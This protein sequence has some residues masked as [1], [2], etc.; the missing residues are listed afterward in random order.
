MHHQT[1]A[2][3]TSA[4]GRAPHFA[5]LDSLRG[6]AA[7]TVVFF[8]V[9]WVNPTEPLRIIR[10]G[11]LM[12]DLFFVLSGF[13]ISYA[14][15][16]RLTSLATVRRFM[17]LRFWRLYPV[18]FVFLIVYLLIECLKWVVFVRYGITSTYRPFEH[19]T[20]AA[21]VANLFL[22]H[23]LFSHAPNS[24]NTPSWSISV[25]F[26]TYIVFAVVVL[27]WRRGTTVVA[28]VLAVGSFAVLA[29]LGPYAVTHTNDYGMIRCLTG[30]F[31]GVLTFRAFE[32]L[33]D[34]GVRQQQM[35]WAAVAAMAIFAVYLGL[36]TPGA[37][38]FAIYPLSALVIL[39][40]A[41]AGAKGPTA[42][43]GAKPVVWLGTVSYSLYM[44]HAAVLWLVT[45]VIKYA[46]HPP[47]VVL[48]QHE[49]PVLA[50]SFWV[51][52]AGICAGIVLTLIVAGFSYRFIEKPFRDWSRTP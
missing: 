8:H 39:A 20:P 2:P 5:A 49:M 12:V 51:G 30:F 26:Y 47:E 19:A 29:S 31:L 33:R 25:E 21:F 9:E 38:D 24:F 52:T 46:T 4:V 16:Q 17:W 27:L 6:I 34:I 48:P 14:Y 36:K 22:V 28:L 40:V 50:P 3:K 44:A 43:L 23:A 13:V 18:H 32:R 37:S 15:G 11:Y 41:L 10:N 1:E 35:G 7:L 42:F 45:Q